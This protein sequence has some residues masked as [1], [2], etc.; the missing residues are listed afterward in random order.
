MKRERF[1]QGALS[2]GACCGAGVFSVADKLSAQ[3]Q[4]S[5]EPLAEC[6]RK[7]SHCRKAVVRLVNELEKKIDPETCQ[8]IMEN[9]G[10]IC[11]TGSHGQRPESGPAPDKAAAFLERLRKSLG[12]DAVQ[13]SEN[14][15]VIYYKYP[16]EPG[17]DKPRCF[18]PVFE[19]DAGGVS[20][21]YCLCSTGYVKETFERNLG[22]RVEVEVLQSVLRG[23]S[24]CEFRVTVRS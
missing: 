1:I 9:C 3:E 23:G 10:R 19:A 16:Q 2:L 13:V 5:V 4:N 12:E 6:E 20:P 22:G 17:T 8:T 21:M 18:C 14:V 11:F 7:V 24:G 15:T